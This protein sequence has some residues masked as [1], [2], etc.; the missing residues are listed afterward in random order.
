[1][2]NCLICGTGH[3]EVLAGLATQFYEPTRQAWQKLNHIP[4]RDLQDDVEALLRTLAEAKLENWPPEAACYEKHR[5]HNL[6]N[7]AQRRVKLEEAAREGRVTGRLTSLA[8]VVAAIKREDIRGLLEDFG[9]LPAGRERNGRYPYFCPW[10]G[11]GVDKSAS[12]LVYA[13]EQ[14]WWC[15][16]CNAGGDA[17]EL[18]KAHLHLEFGDAVRWLVRR[19]QLPIHKPQQIPGTYKGIAGAFEQ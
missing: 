1:M 8:E 12:G 13:Q 4:S 11:D 6:L 17:I 10:H 18:I 7:E 5:L 3:N 9:W 19:F 2:L 15:F 16:G 14:R